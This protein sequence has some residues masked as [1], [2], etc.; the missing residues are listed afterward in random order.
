MPVEMQR[1]QAD[2]SGGKTK[3]A[4][5]VTNVGGGT[6]AGPMD[7]SCHEYAQY[8]EYA[9]SALYI[10]IY[11][12]IVIYIYIYYEY[13]RNIQQYAKQQHEQNLA[14]HVK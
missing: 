4:V 1:K 3:T 12:Y 13:A 8:G 9:Q 5:P 2:F 7:L 14:K 6:S 11:A 10:Y